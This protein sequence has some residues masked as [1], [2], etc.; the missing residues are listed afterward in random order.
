V[1]CFADAT[2]EVL[3]ASLRP[4]NAA[5]HVP[6]DL[7]EVVDVGISQLPD[8][9]ADGHRIGDGS[10]LAPRE[11]LVR[12]DSAGA[13]K[14]FVE[15]CRV[16]NLGFQVVARRNAAISAAVAVANSDTDRWQPALNQDG[17]EVSMA[18]CFSPLAATGFPRV[19][20]SVFPAYGHDVSP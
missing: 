19:R 5:A 16:R 4:G 14:A 17:T 20:S 15:G 10:E 12:S 6:S 7:L 2:G 11:I 18:I 1:F 13:T 8:Q 3:A 9:V